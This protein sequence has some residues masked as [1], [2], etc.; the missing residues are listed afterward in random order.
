MP[1]VA[2]TDTDTKERGALQAVWP[3]IWLLLC[4]FH[5]RQCWTNR[6]KS[7]KFMSSKDGNISFWNQHVH[8]RLQ[9]LEVRCVL[10]RDIRPHFC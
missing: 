1:F 4:K 3:G 7:L 2:I 10:T 8:R 6:R 5:V 9:D